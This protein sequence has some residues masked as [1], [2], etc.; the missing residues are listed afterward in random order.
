VKLRWIKMNS[1]SDDRHLPISYM[2]EGK[3]IF[4]IV[5]KE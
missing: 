5:N 4:S 3:Q 1:S 2:V